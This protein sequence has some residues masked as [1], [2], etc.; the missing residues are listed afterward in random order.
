MKEIFG[1]V[2]VVILALVGYRWIYTETRRIKSISPIIFSEALYILLG[3]LVG[4][5][6]FNFLDSEILEALTPLVYLGLGWIGILFG[7]QLKFKDI[8]KFPKSFLGITIVQSVVPAAAV[9]LAFALYFAHSGRVGMYPGGIII[10]L[11][12]VFA[13]MAACTSQA[14]ITTISR[15]VKGGGRRN[16]INLM[17]YISS[18]DDMVAIPLVGIAFAYEGFHTIGGEVYFRWWDMLLSTLLLG[19]LSGFI[20]NLIVRTI[21]D[22]RELILVIIG[23]VI[24][25]VGGAGY[26]NVSP[27]LMAAVSGIVLANLSQKRDEIMEILLLG[28]KPIFLTFLIIV[29]ALLD[30]SPLVLIVVPIYI[31]IRLLGKVAGGFGAALVFKTYF[32]IP[33]NIGLGLIPQGSMAVAIAL[34]FSRAAPDPLGGLV[35]FSAAASILV[36]EALAPGAIRFVLEDAQGGDPKKA[37]AK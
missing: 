29:G 33:K 3:L 2:L 36:N 22:R 31:G 5:T 25:A 30:F 9:F 21:E 23:T 32:E 35:I 20:L 14:S 37:G 17:R 13:S 24:L 34:C 15:E 26:L 6:F 1:L 4:P 19:L 16:V 7:I 28:E 12:F 18:L 10:A 8:A 27:L 11:L